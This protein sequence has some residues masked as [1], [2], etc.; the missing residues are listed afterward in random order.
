MVSLGKDK[1]YSTKVA[2]NVKAGLL[3]K[4]YCLSNDQGS[5][6]FWEVVYNLPIARTPPP[7]TPVGGMLV[8]YYVRLILIGAQ[9]QGQPGYNTVQN[10]WAEMPCATPQQK[11]FSAVVHPMLLLGQGICLLK[12]PAD[13]LV[14]VG[15]VLQHRD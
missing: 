8:R 13:R 12:D 3:L 6:E 11:E 10:S 14:I 5:P 4:S 15:G 7:L 1:P 2:F 9:V